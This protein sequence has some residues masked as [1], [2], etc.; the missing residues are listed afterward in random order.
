MF[1]RILIPTDGSDITAKAI[2]TA[3]KGGMLDGR[4]P[5]NL[6]D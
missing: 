2:D 3:V 6:P 5:T 1:Q 4:P